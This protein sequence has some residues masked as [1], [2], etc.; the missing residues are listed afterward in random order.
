MGEEELLQAIRDDFLVIRAE[1]MT[2]E[3]KKQVTMLEMKRLNEMIPLVNEGLEKAMQEDEAIMIML[4]MKE[5]MKQ[6]IDLNVKLVMM[7]DSGKLVGEEIY[8]EE[9]LEELREDP[10]VYFLSDN[11][12][13]YTSRSVAGEKQFFVVTEG[14]PD[15]ITTDDIS[16]YVDTIK[17]SAPSTEA[18][19]YLK[20]CF[21]YE[22]DSPIVTCII[23]YTI[24]GDTDE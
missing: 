22:P 16:R 8:D 19:H 12:V 13:S 4:D 14:T 23:G 15:F 11:F 1:K 21:G 6:N 17:V 10:S 9:E 5:K 7:S 24:Q 18:D 3:M 20:H 2:D